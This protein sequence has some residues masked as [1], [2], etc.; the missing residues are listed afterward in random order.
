MPQKSITFDIS[1]VQAKFTG[2]KWKKEQSSSSNM[3]FKMAKFN[4]VERR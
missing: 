2:V 3:R 4:N 1:A